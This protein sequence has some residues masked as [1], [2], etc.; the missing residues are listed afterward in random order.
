M[1]G[2][3]AAKNATLSA[4]MLATHQVSGNAT[5]QLRVAMLTPLASLALAPLAP[6]MTTTATAGVFLVTWSAFAIALVML[7]RWRDLL[8]VAA[9]AAALAATASLTTEAH[10][11]PPSI[12]SKQQLATVYLN[13]MLQSNHMSDLRATAPWMATA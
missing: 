3:Y 4:C 7:W 10:H 12:P 8:A 9:A 1:M 13:Q 5:R 11:E 6:V 2:S